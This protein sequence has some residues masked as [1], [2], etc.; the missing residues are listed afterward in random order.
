MKLHTTLCVRPSLLSDKERVF[1]NMPCTGWLCVAYT[2]SVPCWDGVGEKTWRSILCVLRFDT[3]AFLQCVVLMSII[4]N[5]ISVYAVVSVLSL[6][7]TLYV[8]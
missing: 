1:A 3:Q 5:G 2:T 8:S 4:E 7:I 6:L